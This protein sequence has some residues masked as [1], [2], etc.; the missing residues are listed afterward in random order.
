MVRGKR[1]LINAVELPFSLCVFSNSM[2]LSHREPGE[3][4]DHDHSKILN[5]SD[6]ERGIWPSALKDAVV[7]MYS[8]VRGAAR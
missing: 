1:K 3:R 2:S 5:H 6:F 8:G 4:D 7:W